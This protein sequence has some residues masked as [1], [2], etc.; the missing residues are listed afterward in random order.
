M[1]LD[2]CLTRQGIGSGVSQAKYKDQN[3][4]LFVRIDLS[5]KTQ[6]DIQDFLEFYL[7]KLSKCH[8]VL[9]ENAV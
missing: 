2:S 7:A 3:E 5:T 9:Q 4:H 1:E 6:S 8:F